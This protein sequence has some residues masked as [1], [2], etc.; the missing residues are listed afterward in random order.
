MVRPVSSQLV[1]P[2]DPAAVRVNAGQ[3]GQD[4]LQRGGVGYPD[5]TLAVTPTTV[6][7]SAFKAT[8]APP[9]A[10]DVAALGQ[11]AYQLVRPAPGTDPA[12]PGPA[13]E[14]GWL[15]RNMPGTAMALMAS[16]SPEMMVAL[17]AR[18]HRRRGLPMKV[19]RIMR[20]LYSEVTA[21]TLSTGT[22][23]A[24]TQIRLRLS[25]IAIP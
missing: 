7:A 20:E 24:V 16:P 11:V 17:A 22:A 12:G 13:V 21:V 19:V 15:S 1:L 3:F 23:V 4:V 10:V 18:T 2:G 5:L 14:I 9:G 8:A 25:S 6:P